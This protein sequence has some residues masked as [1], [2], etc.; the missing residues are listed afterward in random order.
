[1]AAQFDRTGWLHPGELLVLAAIALTANMLAAASSVGLSLDRH[2]QL[3]TLDDPT[4]TSG[5]VFGGSVALDGEFAVVGAL[6]HGASATDVGEAHLF[7]ARTGAL[8]RSFSDPTPSAFDFFGRSV[9]ING[10][11]VLI[12]ANGDDT[13]GANIGQAHLFDVHSGQLVRTFDNPTPSQSFHF[14]ATLAIQG[15]IAAIGAP[16]G[17]G[18]KGRVH[19]FDVTSGDLLRTISPPPAHI[20]SGFGLRVAFDADYVAIGAPSNGVDSDPNPGYVGVFRAS[21]G[22]LLHVLQDPTP[23]GGDAFGVSLAIDGRRIIVGAS[24]D[25]TLAPNAGQAHM[26]DLQTGDLLYTLS[27]DQGGS[28]QEFGEAVAL[29]GLAVLVGAVGDRT[30]SRPGDPN[31]FGVGRAYLFEAS[32]GVLLSVIDD[33]TPTSGDLFGSSVAIEGTIALIGAPADDTA[34]PNVGQAYGFAIDVPEPLTAAST[35]YA[36][37]LAVGAWPVARRRAGIAQR[38]GRH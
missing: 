32:A 15:G 14:G 22:D 13:L 28:H 35:V 12:G 6:G 34:G 16:G 38:S 31:R 5:D 24:G 23:T 1:V 33:P 9:A 26:F 17:G 37:A 19:L 30:L 25:D 10:R 21:S 27:P 11:Y 20:G 4:V 2:K 3:H 36:I 7:N 29:D 18:D 8:L